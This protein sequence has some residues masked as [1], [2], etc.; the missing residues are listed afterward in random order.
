M[1]YTAYIERQKTMIK[2]RREGEL[3]LFTRGEE[4]EYSESDELFSQLISLKGLNTEERI[5]ARSGL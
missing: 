4:R 3:I 1:T 5:N 2:N